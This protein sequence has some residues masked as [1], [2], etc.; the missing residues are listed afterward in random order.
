MMRQAAGTIWLLL[1]AC[2]SSAP[3]RDTRTP[4]STGAGAAIP[5]APA[6]VGPIDARAQTLDSMLRQAQTDRLAGDLNT[7]EL[8]LETALR[9]AP[10]DARLWLEL[11][12]IRLASGDYAA[13]RTTADRAVSLSGGNVQIVEASR[14]I[15]AV[16]TR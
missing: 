10:N 16:A 12:E 3:D 8:T 7:A 6:P 2:I 9:I 11:A 1:S 4:E 5:D 15:H 14:R 13:A